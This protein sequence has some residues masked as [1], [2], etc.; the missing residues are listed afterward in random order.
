MFPFSER[1]FFLIRNWDLVA[2]KP[3]QISITSESVLADLPQGTVTGNLEAMIAGIAAGR[4]VTVVTVDLNTAS[5][6]DKRRMQTIISSSGDAATR[7]YSTGGWG[8]WSFGHNDATKIFERTTNG[9]ETIANV[10]PFGS[11]Q[12]VA[13]NN[14]TSG[15]Y[16]TTIPRVLLTNGMKVA[17]CEAGGNSIATLQRSGSTT[18]YVVTVTSGY[19]VALYG[20]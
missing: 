15:T 4:W 18:A 17:V 8:Q 16:S 1:L 7:L 19:S 9:N 20:Y 14:T 6:N 5:G 12:L 11:F 3:Y 10:S 2:T 13:W